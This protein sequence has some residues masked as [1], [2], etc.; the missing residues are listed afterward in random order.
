MQTRILYSAFTI[1][2]TAALSACQPEVVKQDNAS[3]EPQ[4]E[5]IAIEEIQPEAVP[6]EEVQDLPNIELSE[7]EDFE[8]FD[9]DFDSFAIDE[10][11]LETVWQHVRAGFK[12]EAHTDKK[13]MQSELAWYA[14]H[15]GYIQRVMERSD[16]FL[17][18]I[19]SEAEKR[20]LP[21][22]LVLLPIV[23]SA[24]QPFAYSHGRA[25]GLWQFIPATG[26]LYGLKQNWWYDGRRDIYASTQAALKYLTNLNKLFK[27][28]WLLALAAYNS[29]SGTVQRA[30]RKNKK[31]GKPT[32]FWNLDL[33]RETRSYVPKLLALKELIT[34]PQKYDISLRCIPH[35]PGFK[36]IDVGSQID[37]AL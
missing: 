18:Y 6:V 37:L 4:P 9:M 24:F 15:K 27:D 33:P 5:I 16:P 10:P 12:L 17:H 14:G 2:T 30:I 34:H 7:Q 26:R 19:L 13:L 23:E 11:P 20:N 32:D 1:L 21:T 22:E 31:R 3:V 8:S 25:A 35:V 28:D 29:G 36:R